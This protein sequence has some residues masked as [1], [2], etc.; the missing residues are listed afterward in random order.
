MET[1]WIEIPIDGDPPLQRTW[2]QVARQ[3][4]TSCTLT[5]VARITHASENITFP[6]LHFGWR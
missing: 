5:P 2:D 6:Q 3:E 1:P 4:V